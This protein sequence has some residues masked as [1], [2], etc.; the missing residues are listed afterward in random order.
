MKIGILLN[1]FIQEHKKQSLELIL[2]DPNFNINLAIIDNKKPLTLMQ[3]LLKNL[4][5][6][7]GGYVFIMAINKLLNKKN[8]QTN[9]INFLTDN[10]IQYIETANINSADKA[11]ATARFIYKTGS[12][13]KRKI[14]GV[15][16]K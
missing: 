12:G 14:L 11:G 13:K 7:R 3:K 5:R 4:K 6:G 16:L 15:G 10:N 9:T 2:N 8:K 1:Y